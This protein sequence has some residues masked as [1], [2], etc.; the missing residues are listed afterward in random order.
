MTRSYLTM[1]KTDIEIT[2]E[3]FKAV[4]VI[5]EKCL[6]SFFLKFLFKNWQAKLMSVCGNESV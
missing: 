4:E 6:V 3:T 5:A 2:I 1:P